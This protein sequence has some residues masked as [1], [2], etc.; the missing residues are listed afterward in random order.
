MN[1]VERQWSRKKADFL[2]SKLE[3]ERLPIEIQWMDVVNMLRR[4]FQV[5][6]NLSTNQRALQKHL[7]PISSCVSQCLLSGESEGGFMHCET[8]YSEEAGKTGRQLR[9]S[10]TEIFRNRP[11]CWQHLLAS[12]AHNNKISFMIFRSF[13][14]LPLFC[15]VV[16]SH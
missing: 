6:L 1:G 15:C 3:H 13:F 8:K 12:L 16:F 7:Q 11:D 10:A 9:Y 2:R 14:L 5:N 4:V